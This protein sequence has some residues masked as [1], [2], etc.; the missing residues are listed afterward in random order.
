MG[1]KLIIGDKVKVFQ[2]MI[3][4]D[5]VINNAVII[6]TRHNSA[7]I[8]DLDTNKTLSVPISTLTLI[9]N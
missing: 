5:L 1:K 7:I 4:N 8:K 2:K 6:S 9:K 3:L